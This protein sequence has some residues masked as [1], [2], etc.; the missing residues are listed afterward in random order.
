MEPQFCALGWVDSE[1]YGYVTHPNG[2]TTPCYGR[3]Y[4]PKPLPPKGRAPV[5]INIVSIVEPQTIGAGT[6]PTTSP[7]ED[8]GEGDKLSPRQTRFQNDY[9]PA[10][11]CQS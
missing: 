1:G 9:P 7:T 11:F 5:L 10:P 6:V 3:P 4:V 2:P 8:L